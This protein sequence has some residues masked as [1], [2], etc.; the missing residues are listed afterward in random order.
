MLIWICTRSYSM[1]DP[2]SIYDPFIDVQFFVY[3]DAA[4]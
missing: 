3:E 1:G 2:P 4:L